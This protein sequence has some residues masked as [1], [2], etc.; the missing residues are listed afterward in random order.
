MFNDERMTKEVVRASFVIFAFVLVSPF[1]IRALSF[2][3]R[4][5]PAP[6]TLGSPDACAQTLQLHN[7]AVID[8][9]IHVRA[10]VFMYH[11]NTSGSAASNISLSMPISL[12]NFAGRSVR[13]GSTFSVMPSLSIMMISAP[14]P[15]N[16]FA[17]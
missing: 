9:E 12:M 13:H 16:R 10:V 8:K 15:K 1:V 3:V 2:L 7:L 11:A 5:H 6:Q 14:A 4:H 17:W